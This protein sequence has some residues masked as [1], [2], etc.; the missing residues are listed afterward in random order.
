MNAFLGEALLRSGSK[1]QA[2][3]SFQKALDMPKPD[4]PG[5]LAGRKLLD[6]IITARM[7]GGD[8]SIF[9]TPAFSGCHSCHLAA[10]DKLLPR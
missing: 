5:Q 10:P 7:N 4:D 1:E 3:R 6:S 9:E 2:H 8:K